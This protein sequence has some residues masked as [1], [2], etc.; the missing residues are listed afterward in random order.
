MDAATARSILTDVI[1]HLPS[2]QWRPLRE[3]DDS[4]SGLPTAFDRP[5]AK[6]D[7]LLINAEIYRTYGQGKI[8][9]NKRGWDAFI[10]DLTTPLAHGTVR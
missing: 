1:R 10:S 5:R 3:A 4:D 9:M 6:F 7:A 2:G 8:A